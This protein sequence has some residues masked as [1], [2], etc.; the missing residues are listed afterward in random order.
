MPDPHD[1]ENRMKDNDLRQ[2]DALSLT[3]LMDAGAGGRRLWEPE[4]LGA[5]LAHQLAAP[6]ACDLGPLDKEFD[7]RLERFNAAADPPIRTF[8]DLLDHPCPPVELLE[9]TKRFAKDCRNHP[10]GP[11][12]DEIA[13]VLYFLSIVAAMTRCGRRIT[14]MDDSSLRYSLSWALKQPWLD[15]PSRKLIEAGQETLDVA[16]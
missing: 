13:T 9:L 2:S 6:L 14:G 12:P 8:G 3:H 1:D 11:L 7:Q 10:D 4:E 15:E 5:I 16:S